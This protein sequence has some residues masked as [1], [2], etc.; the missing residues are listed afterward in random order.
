MV[1]KSVIVSKVMLKLGGGGFTYSKLKDNKV[2]LTPDEREKVKKL[3]AEWSDGRSAIF[4][5]IINN[6]SYYVTH[7]HRAFQYS[8]TIEGTAKMFHNFIKDTA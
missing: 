6:K 5:S 4:K 2:N 8:P 3:K 1:S 7:T